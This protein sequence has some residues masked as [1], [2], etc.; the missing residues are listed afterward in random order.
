M[1]ESVEPILNDEP[2][3]ALDFSKVHPGPAFKHERQLIRARFSPD[4][5][6]VAAAGL[7]KIIH[8]WELKSGRKYTLPGHASWISALVF[9]PKGRQ[10][11]TADFHGTICCW[12]YAT[13][14]SKP[15]Y[16]IT[17]A[18]AHVTRALAI[19]SD[20]ATLLSGGDDRVVRGWRTKDGAKVREWSGHAG[21]IFSL[22]VHPEGSAVVSGDLFGKVKHWD[23]ATGDL[24]RDLDAGSLHTRKEDFIADV[25]GVRCLTF[26]PKG[27]QLACGGLTAAE[28][29]TFCPGV[30]LALVFD[31]QSGQV[32]R[33]L[34][35]GQKSD[36]PINA[37]RFLGDGT[38]AGYGE[39]QGGAATELAFWTPGKAE[40]AHSWKGASAYDL[41]LHPDG[42]H[43]L[44]PLFVSMGSGGNG[45]RETQKTNYLPNASVVQVFHL[46]APSNPKSAGNIERKI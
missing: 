45:A 30:P 28:S 25:G 24:V 43:L 31:W 42:L 15:L 6:L 29:N 16:T 38:I 18:D 4:G 32:T 2:K 8:L 23:L 35:L 36:G 41:D 7:D 19:T 34:K 3:P 39:N 17:G 27:I 21:C 26:D 11:F 10:L 1:P 12:D 13:P 46:F 20:G 14:G 44:A 33:Q 37:L 9:H 40:P 5:T 22:A